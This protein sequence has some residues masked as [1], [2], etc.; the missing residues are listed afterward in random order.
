MGCPLTTTWNPL[1]QIEVPI[2]CWPLLRLQRRHLSYQERRHLLQ[3]NTTHLDLVNHTFYV[4]D[5]EQNRIV[6]GDMEY[7]ANAH[8]YSSWAE[9]IV[10]HVPEVDP[11][12][13]LEVLA[14]KRR[15]LL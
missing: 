6:R 10:T 11:L 8:L 1:L 14:F 3:P 4:T 15:S 9:V 12:T 7:S 2:P 5:I 13:G